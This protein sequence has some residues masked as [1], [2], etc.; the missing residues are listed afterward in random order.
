MEFENKFAALSVAYHKS[1]DENGY[2]QI[3]L[4]VEDL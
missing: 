1:I 4:F 3:M 2:N